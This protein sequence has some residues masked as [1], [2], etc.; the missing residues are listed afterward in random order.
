MPS[1]TFLHRPAPAACGS[2]PWASREA[3]PKGEGYSADSLLA[4]GT[5]SSGHIGRPHGPLRIQSMD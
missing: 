3:E 1:S 5:G 2:R 4:G